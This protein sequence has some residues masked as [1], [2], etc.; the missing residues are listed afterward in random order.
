MENKALSD[1][2]AALSNQAL[3]QGCFSGDEKA[4]RVLKEYLKFYA[5]VQSGVRA[6]GPLLRLVAKWISRLK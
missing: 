4:I 5:R 2:D 1:T 3:L 6:E